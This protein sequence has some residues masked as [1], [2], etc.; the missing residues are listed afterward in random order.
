MAFVFKLHQLLNI[1]LHEE[2]EAKNRLAQKDGQIAELTQK[3]Q[4]FADD[5]EKALIEQRDALLSGDM[6]SVQM[7][8]PY[9]AL[10]KKQQTFYEDEKARQLKQ[11]EKIM[12]ELLQKQ[13]KRKT[14]EKMQDADRAKYNKEQQKKQQKILDEFGSRKR[15][16]LM[17]DNDA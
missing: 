17:E 3:I 16:T 9:L 2:E 11:R 4:K 5:Q 7:Y 15:N 6:A 12:Q 14:F 13:R 1:A 10:L 8:P